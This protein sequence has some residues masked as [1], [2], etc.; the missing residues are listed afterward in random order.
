MH[1][2]PQLELSDLIRI[3]DGFLGFAKSLQRPMTS[4]ERK[5]WK[6]IYLAWNAESIFVEFDDIN[7]DD[8]LPLLKRLRKLREIFEPDPIKQNRFTCERD[9]VHAERHKGNNKLKVKDMLGVR[10]RGMTTEEA[11]DRMMLL[12]KMLMDCQYLMKELSLHNG[13]NNDMTLSY[14]FGGFTKSGQKVIKAIDDTISHAIQ[15]ERES[16]Q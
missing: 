14:E 10:K 4:A 12:R 8:D 3:T 16:E 7:E 2:C 11:R 15:E 13:S 9:N 5:H 1:D 6:W